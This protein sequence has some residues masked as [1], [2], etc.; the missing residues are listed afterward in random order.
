M[1]PFGWSPSSKNPNICGFCTNRL[2]AGGAEVPVAVFVADV[3][4][5]SGL[6]ER[7][8]PLELAATMSAFFDLLTQTLIRH[9]ALIDKYMGDGLQAL[10]IQGVAGPDY[11]ERAIHAA[12]AARKELAMARPPLCDLPVGMAL[13]SGNAFVGNVGGADIVDLTA[14]GDVVNVANRLQGHAAGG[15]LLIGEALY[16]RYEHDIGKAQVRALDLKGKAEPVK[17]F[18]VESVSLNAVP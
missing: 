15:E 7:T 10:F 16:A 17:A 14:M 4:D 18:L 6:S 11:E 13:H 2:P 12:L 9:D 8:P 1:R 5:Y 3:R